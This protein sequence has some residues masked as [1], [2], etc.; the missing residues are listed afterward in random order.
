M[1]STKNP[2]NANN[3]P[4]SNEERDQLDRSNKK[5]KRKITQYTFG[6]PAVNDEE[7]IEVNAEGH[8]E[9][10]V[11]PLEK[12]AKANP[13]EGAMSFRDMLK[14]DS[15]NG[16]IN[17]FDG[18]IDIDEED[19]NLESDD[20]EI[21]EEILKDDRCPVI[22][23]SKEEKARLRKPWKTSLILKLFSGK[24]GYMG[25]IRR[26]KKKW[27]IR[28]ELA[29]TDIGCDYYIARFTNKADYNYVLSQGP[30]LL[31]DNYLTIRK[32]IPNFIPDE[33][34][35]KILTAWVRI[36]NLLV[37]YFDINFLNKVGSKI[38]KVLRVDK[39]TAQAER[40]QF[41]RI[42]VEIDLTKPLLSMF[43]LK[44][45]IWRVQYE[46]IRMICFK[47]G[48]LGHAEDDCSVFQ[49][50]D[51]PQAMTVHENPLHNHNPR[52]EE[53]ED[54]GSWMMVKKPTRKKNPRVEKNPNNVTKSN[55]GGVQI[56][57]KNQKSALEQNK[58]NKGI[59]KN[60]GLG[61][62][63]ALLN[64]QLEEEGDVNKEI[65]MENED[66][67][68]SPQDNF[69]NI[70]ET[71]NLSEK[72]QNILAKENITPR[73]KLNYSASTPSQAKNKK[74]ISKTYQEKKKNLVHKSVN[75]PLKEINDNTDIIINKGVSQSHAGKENSI[76]ALEANSISIN[77]AIPK[78]NTSSIVSEQEHSPFVEG[79]E[80]ITHVSD[81][82]INQPIGSYRQDTMCGSL[83]G[84][85]IHGKFEPPDSCFGSGVRLNATTNHSP[86]GVG[87]NHENPQ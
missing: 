55:S 42:S 76:H 23:L 45:R 16:N 10:M 85:S 28:G 65:N 57:E 84:G 53:T 31:D 56:L 72:S 82:L 4:S 32:W 5:P 46:G 7:M 48:K 52:L 11:N 62:R 30:W 75:A 87:G 19:E 26:L 22:S 2:S 58:S 44:G 12:Q 83:D 81:S 36:P 24:I 25:L 38:G 13:S 64:N 1:L 77:Q 39:T 60:K 69:G 14:G 43:W 73:F 34:P 63:F 20:E 27:N 61:S 40:G 86:K 50:E 74:N 9:S 51:Q 70:F 66:M 41:T 67:E 29:L 33:A 49:K 3:G 15:S 35:I 47:C 6:T 79:G 8:K 80:A 54:F 78:E 68:E 18:I 21:P 71:I 37:E 59:A 17:N